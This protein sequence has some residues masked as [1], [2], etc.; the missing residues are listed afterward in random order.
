MKKTLIAA[1][2]LAGFSGAA[3]AET[4]VT[5]YGLLDAGIGYQQIKGD[6][7][8]TS[9]VGLDS[10]TQNGSRWGMR[11]TEDLGNGLRAVFNL[12]SG[13]NVETGILR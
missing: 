9:K 8:S 3:Q 13:F 11:G 5:L 10:G 4:Q 2:L 6:G 1:A 12:E 7:F